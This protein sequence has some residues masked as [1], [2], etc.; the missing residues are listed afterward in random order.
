[1][2]SVQCFAFAVHHEVLKVGGD[3]NEFRRPKR[4]KNLV[5]EGH[6]SAQRSASERTAL[7]R[8]VMLDAWLSSPTA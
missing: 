1:M 3:P 7:I 6:S 4:K 5:N 2:K 8:E